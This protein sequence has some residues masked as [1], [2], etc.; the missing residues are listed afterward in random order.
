MPEFLANFLDTVIYWGSS[1][2]DY[3]CT[4]EI[5]GWQKEVEIV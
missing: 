3:L 1:L 2:L 4:A 5:G